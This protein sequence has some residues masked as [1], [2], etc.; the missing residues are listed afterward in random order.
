MAQTPL[1][2]SPSRVFCGATFL[3]VLSLP[4][5]S[6]MIPARHGCE[7]RQMRGQSLA[8]Q[9]Y[10][11]D[12]WGSTLDARM[13]QNFGK[14]WEFGDDDLTLQWERACQREAMIP[15]ASLSLK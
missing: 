8:R 12:G 1:A 11:K 10:L 3:A 9:F 2:A 4:P 7:L 14:D 5:M 13:E 6:L 15:E